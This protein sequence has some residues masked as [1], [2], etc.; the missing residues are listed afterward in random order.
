MG[1]GL[2]VVISNIRVLLR[3][4]W[5]EDIEFRDQNVWERFPQMCLHDR[6]EGTV[7]RIITVLGTVRFDRTRNARHL[8]SLSSLEN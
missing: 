7:R 2:V 1:I 5:V 4:R 8:G 3:V 6:P